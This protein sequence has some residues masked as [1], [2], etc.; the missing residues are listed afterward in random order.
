MADREFFKA[1]NITTGAEVLT[2]VPPAVSVIS[3]MKLAEAFDGSF[4]TGF[5]AAVYGALHRDQMLDV[6]R[7][8]LKP[9]AFVEKLVTWLME[10]EPDT[11]NVY[12]ADG[13]VVIKKSDE[14]ESEEPDPLP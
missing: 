3:R 12:D 10:W 8:K 5:Y 11:Q 14:D 7:G 2:S 4:I 6:A 1:T 13:N 9:E